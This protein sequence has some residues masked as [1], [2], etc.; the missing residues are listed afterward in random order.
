MQSNLARYGLFS[1]V[2]HWLLALATAALLGLGWYL[3][4]SPTTT[5]QRA[6][7]ADIH[8]SL[9]LTTAALLVLAVLSRLLVGAPAY[10]AQTPRW[11]RLIGAWVNALIYLA[12]V[13]VLAS[14]YLR[15]IFTAAPV[16][17]WGTPLPSWGEP[18]D[19]LAEL[20]A[21]TH[22]I[23]AF[24]L[25]GLVVVHIGL[26]VANSF[27]YPGFASRM[28]P[29][30][31]Q[32][33]ESVVPPMRMSGPSGHELGLRLAGQMR[34]LGWTKFWIQFVL[35]FLSALLLQ[36]ATS[37]RAL[38]AAQAGFGDAIYW[39]GC[40]LALLFLTCAL[41]YH[42]T[43][44]ARKIALAPERYL[45]G[46]RGSGL[47]FLRAGM[48]F[49]LLG[50]FLSFIGV[51]LSI[52]LLIAKT[53]S[54]PPGIAITDPTKIIRALD[55]FVLLMSFILLLAHFIGVGISVWLRIAVAR[56]R[57]QFQPP[58]QTAIEGTPP[59]AII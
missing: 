7:L 44:R 16:L 53:V 50:V 46:K 2:I 35:A 3:R 59:P 28:L 4:S 17:F 43:R 23:G 27:A 25:A 5:D 40:A 32:A 37:G 39:S 13:V 48:T 15:Q 6:F 47:W 56:A 58:T 31:S 30:E 24:A 26:V 9:G 51:A 36:F 45:G 55:V 33:P 49:G 20:C 18:D 22:E 1:I 8:V 57:V 14:G 19:R 34:L 54:Q 11:R 41:A 10:P 42:Y 12:L 52:S 38:S 21:N 29:G